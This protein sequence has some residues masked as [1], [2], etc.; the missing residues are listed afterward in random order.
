MVTS[1]IQIYRAASTEDLQAVGALRHRCYVEDGLID[2]MERGVFLDPYDYVDNAQVYL[3]EYRGALVASIRLH[4]LDD[5]AGRSATKDAF[6]DI[7]EPMIAAGR[8]ILDGARFVVNP[9]LGATRLAV[10]RQTL[11]IY[12]AA[13]SETTVTYGVAAVQAPQVRFYSR[14][15]GFKQIAEPRAY[16]GL[17]TKLA[18]MGVDLRQASPEVIDELDL[19]HLS[20]QPSAVMPGP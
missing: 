7:V 16:F 13:A 9:D 11:R 2:P 14:I 18:L 6:P 4:I 10:A 19:D 12:A 3:I 20:F 17:K 5:P 8:V 1:E 15:F